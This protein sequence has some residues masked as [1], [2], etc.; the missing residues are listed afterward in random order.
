VKDAKDVDVTE[1]R[2]LTEF[3]AYSKKWIPLVKQFDGIHHGCFLPREGPDNIALVL[4]SFP[5]LAA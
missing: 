2:N 3:E 1:L 5:S 4:F